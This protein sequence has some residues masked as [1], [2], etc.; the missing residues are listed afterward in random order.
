[1]GRFRLLMLAL[2]L[3]F[4]ATPVFATVYVS[5]TGSDVTGDG[6]SGNPYATIQRG[7][8]SAAPAETVQVAAGVY[9]ENVSFGGKDVTVTSTNPDDPA[10]V[11]AT[12]IDGGNA[13]TVVTF[14]SGETSAAVLTG[15]T[16]TNGEAAEGGGI[17]STA[18][19]TITKNVFTENE[20][21][22][23]DYY[24]GG[25]AICARGGSPTIT[26]NTITGNES[27]YMAAGIGCFGCSNVTIEHNEITDNEAY[28][29]GGGIACYATTAVSQLVTIENFLCLGDL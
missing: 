28:Y 8:N 24:R 11:S 15:F 21:T 18:S 29:G 6:S 5:T 14:T 25:G 23:Y 27:A 17:Y 22:W 7:I 1:M 3:F 2:L 19:P 26:Y 13:G 4:A 9:Y 20:C 16:I 12:I 10:V